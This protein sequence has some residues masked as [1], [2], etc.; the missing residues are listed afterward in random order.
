MTEGLSLVTDKKFTRTLKLIQL[1]DIIY[2]KDRVS[3]R[4][5]GTNGKRDDYMILFSE[6]LERYANYYVWWIEADSP[7]CFNITISEVL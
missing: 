6:A 4:E 1:K 7:N 2:D 5:A 3:I